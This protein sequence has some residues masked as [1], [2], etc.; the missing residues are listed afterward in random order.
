MTLRNPRASLVEEE[1]P[2]PWQQGR[3]VFAFTRPG[4]DATAYRLDQANDA[5]RDLRSGAFQ[6]AAVLAPTCRCWSTSGPNG[7][8]RAR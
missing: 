5:L 1:R 3:K 2:D 4:V 6:G 7:V 8:A